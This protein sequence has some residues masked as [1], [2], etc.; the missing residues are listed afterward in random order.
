MY[1]YTYNMILKFIYLFFSIFL[2]HHLIC[3]FFIWRLCK[4]RETVFWYQQYFWLFFLPVV[5]IESDA[6]SVCKMLLLQAKRKI[7][8]TSLS[9]MR[10]ITSVYDI[11]SLLTLNAAHPSVKSKRRTESFARIFRF[12]FV[13]CFMF[14]FSIT[15]S[16]TRKF[17]K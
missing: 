9:I 16:C 7:E 4:E 11:T 5:G 10:M 14:R 15:W 1:I 12:Q 6:T 17:V 2:Y 3:F 13:C 8:W